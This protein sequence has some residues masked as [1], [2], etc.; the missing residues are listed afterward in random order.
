MSA[1]TAAALARVKARI[2]A[3]A[4]VIASAGSDW[5]IR[6]PGPRAKLCRTPGT[7]PVQGETW[8]VITPSQGIEIQSTGSATALIRELAG[9]LHAT[10][11]TDTH[12]VWAF[13]WRPPPGVHT[14][15]VP[16]DT[17]PLSAWAAPM[18]PGAVGRAS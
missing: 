2:P 3:S 7:R 6:W 15:T 17:A 4:E 12:G 11:V 5:D 9:P 10:L 16:G 13:R 14:I 18:A 1:P 8:F